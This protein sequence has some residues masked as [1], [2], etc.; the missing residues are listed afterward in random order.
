M[1]GFKALNGKTNL[2]ILIF[3]TIQHS[4]VRNLYIC[5]RKFKNW[6]KELKSELPTQNRA[7]PVSSVQTGVML[8]SAKVLDRFL[9]HCY[10]VREIDAAC[11]IW[12]HPEE[13]RDRKTSPFG[14][15][16]NLKSVKDRKN[17]ERKKEETQS[18]RLQ[19]LQIFVQRNGM[20]SQSRN[21]RKRL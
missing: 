20:E 9:D 14:E 18:C 6:R 17:L 1:R 16:K 3:N 21:T 15:G 7:I 13:L 11:Y 10:N 4:K 2:N 8:Q 12:M 19:Q 5:Q